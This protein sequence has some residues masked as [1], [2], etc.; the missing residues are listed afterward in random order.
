M[1][2]GNGAG[3]TYSLQQLKDG[4]V[5]GINGSTPTAL[6]VGITNIHAADISSIDLNLNTTPEPASTLLIGGG[7]IGISIALRRKRVSSSKG[8]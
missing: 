5:S 2:G 7:L 3:S 4:A 1:Q 8:Q 6:W